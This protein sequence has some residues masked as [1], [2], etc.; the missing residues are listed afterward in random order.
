[1]AVYVLTVDGINRNERMQIAFFT[2]LRE[3]KASTKDRALLSKLDETKNEEEQPVLH[4]WKWATGLRS[5]QDRWQ[6]VKVWKHQGSSWKRVT[7][8]SVPSL[9]LTQA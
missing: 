4:I 6:S 2:S 8:Q 5:S 9:D 7:A 3:A 1:M